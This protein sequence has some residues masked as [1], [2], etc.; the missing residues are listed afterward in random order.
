M[1]VSRNVLNTYIWEPK[2]V[3]SVTVWRG[4]YTVDGEESDVIRGLAQQDLDTTVAEDVVRGKRPTWYDVTWLQTWPIGPGPQMWREQRTL[5][6]EF[7]ALG[8]ASAGLS[9]FASCSTPELRRPAPLAGRPFGF[10][11]CLCLIK[12]LAS[13]AS[14]APRA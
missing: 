4:W 7:D 14:S 2:G 3:D 5:H 12:H 10:L 11:C 8:K 6:S 13:L 1:R 9:S